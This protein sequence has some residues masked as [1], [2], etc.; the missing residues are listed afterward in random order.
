[1]KLTTEA[2]ERRLSS[3]T[4][5]CKTDVALSLLSWREETVAPYLES[6]VKELANQ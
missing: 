3:E 6:V 4:F 2:S 5:A 1:M